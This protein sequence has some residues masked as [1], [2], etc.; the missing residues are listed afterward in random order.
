MEP[1]EVLGVVAH[2]G[3]VLV[4]RPELSVGVVRAVARPTG[5]TLELLSRVARE[6]AV[7]PPVAP[8]HLLPAYDE[9]LDL[10]VGWLG[11]DD[12]ARWEYVV[13][14]TRSTSPTAPAVHRGVYLLPPLF[15]EVSLVLAWPEIGFP[16]AV[17]PLPLPS[18]ALVA[19]AGTS[20]WDGPRVGVPVAEEFE[21]HLA[22]AGP[23]D[24]AV[25]EGVAVAAPVVLHGSAD[26][27]VVLAGVTVVGPVL[28]L[29]VLSIARGTTAVA[30]GLRAF[31]G[32][33]PPP[34]EEGASVRA[35]VAEVRGR[36]AH[37]L[38]PHGGSVGGGSGPG[39]FHDR[40][41]FVVTRPDGGVLDLLVSWPLA[42]LAEVRARVPLRG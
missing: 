4:R 14:E 5:L 18:R 22:D 12:R 29:D 19:A 1:I 9:G 15:D 42:G 25:E 11:P 40:S 39:R 7:R 26:A 3:G 38:R 17:L 30:V 28:T 41:T 37:L 36:G 10:R 8:R 34:R 6:V 23:L 21:R 16:E 33:G 20:V 13:S 24:L 31:P 2:P 27:V 35:S 32:T